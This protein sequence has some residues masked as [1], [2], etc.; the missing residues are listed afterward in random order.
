MEVITPVIDF[1]TLE[2][3]VIT[4]VIGFVTFEIEVITPVTGFITLEIEVITPVTGFITCV[5]FGD[6]PENSLTPQPPLLKERG[7]VIVRRR[8]PLRCA[9]GRFRTV[10]GERRMVFF[11]LPFV[12][13]R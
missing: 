3:E 11:R 2:I 12:V 6:F 5:D 1:I 8:R 9:R 10:N 4:R 7:S 13:G